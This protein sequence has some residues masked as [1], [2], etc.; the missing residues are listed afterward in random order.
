MGSEF[1]NLMTLLYLAKLDRRVPTDHR[2]IRDRQG[3]KIHKVMKKAYQIPF[4]RKRFDENGL[5]PDDFHSAEDLAKFPVMTR[6][7]LRGWMQE[8]LKD[9]DEASGQLEIFKTS[10]SSGDRGSAC[11]SF[12][13][14]TM[15]AAAALWE[16]ARCF[17]QQV[18]FVC[19]S[20]R[21][22]GPR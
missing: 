21:Y 16:S 18:A 22:C 14:R 11:R 12:F 17:S 9:Y 6:A 20:P 5:T 3:K 1:K 13:S 4:Y 8:V 15:P 2:R 10:G 19:P 7:D